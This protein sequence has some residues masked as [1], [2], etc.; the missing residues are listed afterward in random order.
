MLKFWPSE[1]ADQWHDYKNQAW[2]CRRNGGKIKKKDQE[3]VDAKLSKKVQENLTWVLKK[4]AEAN[5][6][7]NVNLGEICATVSSDNCDGTP[8]IG[9]AATS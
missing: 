4:L 8:I 2:S 9:G 1:L 5:P 7:I 3:E 6:S